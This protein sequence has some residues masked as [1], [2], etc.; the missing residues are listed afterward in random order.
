MR[1]ISSDYR[2]NTQAERDKPIQT[3]ELLRHSD[4]KP[5]G[6][7]FVVYASQ[8]LAEHAVSA[9]NGSNFQGR[10][11]NAKL[12]KEGVEIG[13]GYGTSDTQRP[14]IQDRSSG[15]RSSR[16]SI[17]GKSKEVKADASGRTGKSERHDNDTRRDDQED[18]ENRQPLVANG[19]GSSKDCR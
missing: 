6:H 19:S 2:P 10:T 3:I 4:G 18:C 12:T 8:G 9:I 1:Y 11:I 17:S 13:Y 5:K 7:A 16:E 15:E 14:R